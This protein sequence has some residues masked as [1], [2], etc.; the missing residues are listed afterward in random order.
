MRATSEIDVLLIGHMTADLAPGGKMLGGTVAYAAPTYAAF[1]HRVGILTSAAYD[2]TLLGELLPFGKVLSLPAPRS[3]SYE[4]VYSE[5]GRRQFVRATAKALRAGDVPR[6]WAQAPY[7]HLGPLAAELDP[8]E[9]ARSFPNAT[10]MLTLQGLMRQWGDDGL[11]R[12]RPWFD[13]EA[14][15]L[16]DIVV[17]SQEDIHQAPHL[18]DE[19]REVCQRLVVTNGRHGGLYYEGGRTLRYN[20]LAVEP[21]DLTGAGDV[22]AAA[23]LGLLPLLDGDVAKAVRIAGRLAAYSVTRSGL[24]SAPTAHEIAAELKRVQ[25]EK[26]EGEP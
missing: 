5:Q 21:L 6:A 16:I 1:G 2:E 11:V 7:V 25:A 20:S 9:M 24:D 13:A 14:L 15:R 19:M 26:G 23:L 10:V 3:L 8:L 12:F 4:N 17:Y 18:T 22:F